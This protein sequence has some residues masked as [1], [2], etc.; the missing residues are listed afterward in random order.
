MPTTTIR[1]SE[2]LKARIAHAAERAGTTAHAFI[3]EAIAERVSDEERRNVFHRS[4]EQR[5]ATI[6]AS[7]KTIPWND[8]QA[9]LKDRLAGGKP[10]RP[11]AKKLAR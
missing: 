5:Y 1:L 9:Y 4:A 6:V 3:L 8:M 7:G 2:D 10:A 11:K